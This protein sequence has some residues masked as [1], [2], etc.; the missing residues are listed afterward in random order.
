MYVCTVKPDGVLPWVVMRE[1]FRGCVLLPFREFADGFEI[2]KIDDFRPACELATPLSVR[3]YLLMCPKSGTCSMM[4]DVD[5]AILVGT[6]KG[7]EVR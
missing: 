3:Y 1:A 6:E 2:E 7:A 5:K 4:I